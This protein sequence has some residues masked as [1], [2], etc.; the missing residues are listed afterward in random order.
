MSKISRVAIVLASLLSVA[1]A[2]SRGTVNGTV[3]DS[4]GAVIKGAQVLF[5]PDPSGQGHPDSRADV[6]R[7]TNAAGQFA[8]E[9]ESGFYDVCVMAVAFT[10]ER[11]KTLVRPGGV[12]RYD[13]RLKA[14]PLVT[15][16]LGDT[17]Y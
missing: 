9:L 12:A 3:R 4:E 1:A 13:T 7:E 2:G 10:P 16:H 8:V 5:H 6:T 11:R 17:F 14:D 15:Q